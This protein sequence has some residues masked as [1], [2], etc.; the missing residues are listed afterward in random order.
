MLR[1]LYE[2]SQFPILQ[3]RIYNSF[4]DAINCVCGNIQI[5]ENQETGLI[6][7]HAFEPG[8]VVYDSNYNNEQASSIAF[9][10]H[11]EFV[12]DTIKNEIGISGLIEVGCGKAFF[13][14]MLLS[15]GFDVTGFDPTY[16]GVNPR[17]VKEFF[18]PNV[19]RSGSSLILRHVLEHVCNPYD[20][21]R[22]LRDANGGGL[23]YI[24]V[25]CFDWICEKRAWFDIFYEHVNYFRINDFQRMFGIVTYAEKTFGGQYLSI[26]ADLSTLKP[27]IYIKSEA[28]KFPNDF[29][30]GLSSFE[31]F[32]NQ[33]ALVWGGAS[34]GVIFSLLYERQHKKLL[35]I[36]D[37]NPKKHGGF[38]PSTG[39]KVLS[40]EDALL[41][42]PKGMTVYV[43]NSNYFHEIQCITKDYFNLI[44]I[45]CENDK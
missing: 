34:K 27:P 45:D 38:L 26:I 8:L 39:H 41:I 44:A 16:D 14:E 42:F 36:I 40:P 6:Y 1:I 33:Q 29:L 17:V 4:E 10:E 24:E 31:K 19:I 37:I 30:V 23:I 13:L 11:L 20:F 43:M 21:L 9:R 2:G 15:K 32:D 35:G 18:S 25:P 28:V 3:N 5:V 7:N 12:A 22:Q